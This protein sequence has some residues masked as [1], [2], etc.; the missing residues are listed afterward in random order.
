MAPQGEKKKKKGVSN[1]LESLQ[2]GSVQ[3]RGGRVSWDEAK[4]N[5]STRNLDWT[6]KS[7]VY[8]VN[9]TY[10]FTELKMTCCINI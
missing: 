5:V 4:T 6:P 1:A 10:I 3:K 2:V 9:R 8:F 7:N